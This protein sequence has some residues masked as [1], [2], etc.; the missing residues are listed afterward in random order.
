MASNDGTSVSIFTLHLCATLCTDDITQAPQVP[1][2]LS[3]LTPELLVRVLSNF[4]SLLELRALL[5]ACPACHYVYV[6]NK[7]RILTQVITNSLIGSYRRARG[8]LGHHSTEIPDDVVPEKCVVEEVNTILS[9][10]GSFENFN[11]GHYYIGSWQLL[12]DGTR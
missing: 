4:N 9:S 12:A 10:G 2:R 5:R 1:D 7:R 11:V 3:S 8:R 6:E